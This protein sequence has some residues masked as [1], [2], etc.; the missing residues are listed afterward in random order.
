MMPNGDLVCVSIQHTYPWNM[1]LGAVQD[2]WLRNWVL[3]W[4]NKVATSLQFNF[5][6]VWI[7]IRIPKTYYRFPFFWKTSRLR[8]AIAMMKDAGKGVFSTGNIFLVT[9]YRNWL[10]KDLTV[11]FLSKVRGNGVL[12]LQKNVWGRTLLLSRI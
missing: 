12:S 3:K 11:N 4:E 10:H 9:G 5:S 7:L 6:P 8:R 1:T 2:M